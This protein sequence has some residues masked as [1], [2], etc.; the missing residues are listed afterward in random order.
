MLHE[1][2]FIADGLGI[3]IY[4]LCAN[5]TF[6]IYIREQLFVKLEIKDFWTSTCMALNFFFNDKLLLVDIIFNFLQLAFG[7]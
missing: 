1:A 7:Q 2:S 6:S 4:V 3:N 5:I